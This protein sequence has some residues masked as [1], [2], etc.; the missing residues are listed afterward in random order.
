MRFRLIRDATMPP[1]KRRK[2]AED[3][4]AGYEANRLEQNDVH[5]KFRRWCVDQ[6]IK[7]H[8]AVVAHRFPGKGVGVLATDIIPA[9]TEL[10]SVPASALI[11]VDSD[12]CKHGD[13]PKAQAAHA[14]LTQA[15][16]LDRTSSKL[17]PWEATW[18][19]K[20]DV[21]KSIPLAWDTRW[22]ALLPPEAQRQLKK[23]EAKYENQR[24]SSLLEL[25]AEEWEQHRYIWMLINSRCYYW[26]H[27]RSN[28]PAKNAK[29]PTDECL[30]LVPWADYFNH[31]AEGCVFSSTEQSCKIVT[32]REYA[33]GEEVVVSYGSHSN[34]FLLLEYGF[35]LKDN[36]HDFLR[37]DH[38]F[39]P[40]LTDAQKNFLE[41]FNYL[42][43]YS[44][45]EFGTC[46]RT[47]VALTVLTLGQATARKFLN[48]QKLQK[49]QYLAI[50]KQRVGILEEFF[51]ESEKMVKHLE[52]LHRKG[53]EV[54]WTL[55]GRWTEI[56]DA[57]GDKKRWKDR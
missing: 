42:G 17:Q 45:Y 9:E 51:G 35:T 7:I 10:I 15:L 8:S 3:D 22:K 49:S 55:I 46:W 14:V 48:G 43:N 12:I 40:R 34:D 54:P 29:L 53:E 20:A 57:L 44:L 56:I 28:K 39:L 27:A 19:G 50:D 37:L 31:A 16:F 47:E 13:I 26:P 36:S 2:T 30:A 1:S 41:E 25:D 24:K 38:L 23:Q 21:D 52:D 6:G 4:G 5:V 32:D 18:P 33:K 11:T